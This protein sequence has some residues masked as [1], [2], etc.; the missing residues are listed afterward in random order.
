MDLYNLSDQNSLISQYLNEI[1]DVKIQ[2]DRLRFRTNLKRISQLM[3][4]EVSKKLNYQL[5]NTQTPLA[6]TTTKILSDKIVV[7]SIMRAGLPMHNG[8]LEIF[9]HAENA[10]I[11]AYRI[12]NQKNIKVE[13]EYQS[14]PDLNDK[15]VLLADPMI[16]TGNSI[17][18]CLD[19][20]KKYGQPSHTFILGIVASQHG[21]EKL[22]KTTGSNC[23]CFVATIDPELNEKSYIIPGLGDAGDL[24]FGNKL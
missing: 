1:R 12:E 8:L 7:A 19:H 15:V 4:F 24:A 20:L 17:L 11:S 2:Q 23:S 6:P 9:D 5:R 14:S 21:I 13:V 18:K 3:G 22:K 16:A 10:F